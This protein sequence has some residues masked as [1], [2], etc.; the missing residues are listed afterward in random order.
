MRIVMAIEPRAYREAIGEVFREL[1]P[2][3][4]VLIVESEALVEEVAR[5]DPELVFCAQPDSLVPDGRSAW[6]EFRPYAEPAARVSLDGKYAEL[7]EV[8]LEDLLGV[9]DETEVLSRTTG[10]LRKGAQ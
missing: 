10:A 9:A 3:F 8:E 5:L 4:E 1:R 6:V 2:S 7:E